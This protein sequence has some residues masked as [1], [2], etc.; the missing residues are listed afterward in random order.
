MSASVTSSSSNTNSIRSEIEHLAKEVKEKLDDFDKRIANINRKAEADLYN[1]Q[2]L[3]CNSKE[4]ASACLNTRTK[5]LLQA[6]AK[7]KKR[8]T[9]VNENRERVLNNFKESVQ[10]LLRQASVGQ[11]TEKELKKEFLSETDTQLDMLKQPEHTD[12]ACDMYGLNTADLSESEW[13][14]LI[15][16]FQAIVNLGYVHTGKDLIY[17]DDDEDDKTLS[18][19]RRLRRYFIR[20]NRGGTCR[21]CNNN[22]ISAGRIR[23]IGQWDKAKFVAFVNAYL[24]GAITGMFPDH[25]ALGTP[26]KVVCT[27][28]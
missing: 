24:A 5:G 23:D 27:F 20:A 26:I 28:S 22:A 19:R 9:L 3:E 4:S 1:V 21:G 10:K 11:R 13:E 16:T 2:F 12:A 18:N 7:L 15:D 6:E 25:I 8:I 14:V 17:L